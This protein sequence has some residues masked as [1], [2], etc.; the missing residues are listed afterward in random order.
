MKQQP[1]AY[2]RKSALTS[3][4]V[5]FKYIENDY[6]LRSHERGLVT[7]MYHCAGLLIFIADSELLSIK[8]KISDFSEVSRDA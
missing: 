7:R 1:C 8:N 5:P 3:Y 4:R 2:D 6:M